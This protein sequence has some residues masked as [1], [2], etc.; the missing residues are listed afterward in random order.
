M[1][2][3]EPLTTHSPSTSSARVL[4]APASEPE[5]GLGQPEAGQRAAGDQVGQ[6][7]LFCSSVPKVRTGLMPSPTPASR[8][9]PSDWSTR[10]ISSIATHR[11]VKSPSGAAELLRGGEPEQA[12]VAH[13]LHDVGREVVLA[14]PLRPRAGRSPSR[15]SRGRCARN[16]SCSGTARRTCGHSLVGWFTFTNLR[17]DGH[18]AGM[19]FEARP[20]TRPTW[21]ATSRRCSRCPAGR[22]CAAAGACTTAAP[23][24]WR[25]RRRRRGEQAAAARAG[26]RRRRARAWSATSTARR[27]AGSASA[28]ARTTSSCAARR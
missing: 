26:R 11:L 24:R 4:V 28:R 25:V 15:R 10:P 22:S 27:S 1:N 17:A 23:A 2:C 18:D 12:E 3:L 20:L 9:M 13:L 19:G 5:P 7:G 6:P 16:A 8:V 21:A 14:V